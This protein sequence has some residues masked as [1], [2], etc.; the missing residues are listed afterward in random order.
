MKW[1]N[2]SKFW[3]KLLPFHS[4]VKIV[5]PLTNKIVRQDIHAP[6][7]SKETAKIKAETKNLRTTHENEKLRVVS[8]FPKVSNSFCSAHK[9]TVP[10]TG[11]LLSLGQV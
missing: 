1:I 10:Q 7:L 9:R 5:A 8:N 2:I 6:L 4:S 3:E 11:S